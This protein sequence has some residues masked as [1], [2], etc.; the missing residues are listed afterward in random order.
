MP[1]LGICVSDL[2]SKINRKYLGKQQRIFCAIRQYP[3][4]VSQQ[5]LF[6]C[7]TKSRP[8][9]NEHW[10][11][12]FMYAYCTHHNWK[13]PAT[14]R[15]MCVVYNWISKC[16]CSS[17]MK[18][19]LN[20]DKHNYHPILSLSQC[21]S[22]NSSPS[23]SHSRSHTNTHTYALVSTTHRTKCVQL[24]SQNCV[25]QKLFIKIINWINET[26]LCSDVWVSE[27]V[28][29]WENMYLTFD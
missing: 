2:L 27:W 19:A 24:E 9:I 25:R 4:N 7:C 14:H 20:F 29:F 21:Y 17:R 5:R 13:V 8:K 18:A 26:H 12:A 23:L 11:Y 10:T 6:Y 16:V 3:C 15:W 22:N 28:C 1:K